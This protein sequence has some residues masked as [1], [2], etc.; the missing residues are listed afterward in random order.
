MDFVRSRKGQSIPSSASPSK[1]PEDKSS[2]EG[3][4]LQNSSTE[5]DSSSAA[6][7][8]QKPQEVEMEGVEEEEEEMSSPTAVTG[9]KD[10][11]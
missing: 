11:K 3:F 8:P 5:S 1:H 4:T 2:K 6:V 9:M 7:L 10:S